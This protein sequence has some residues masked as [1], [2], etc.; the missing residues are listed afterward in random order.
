M[1][2]V[3]MITAAL[4]LLTVSVPTAHAQKLD[5]NGRCHDKAGKFAKAEVCKGAAPIGPSAS[6]Y[7]LDAKGH[8]HDPKG[9]MAKKELCKA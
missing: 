5:A 6:G 9:K 1:R 4:S 3:L 8:C 7:K 2:T